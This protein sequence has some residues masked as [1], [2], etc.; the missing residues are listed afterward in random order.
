LYIFSPNVLGHAHGVG[1]A[2]GIS[3]HAEEG[4]M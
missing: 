1:A 4:Y 3:D 2:A